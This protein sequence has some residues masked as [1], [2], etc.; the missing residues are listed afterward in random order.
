MATIAQRIKHLMPCSDALIWLG[1]RTNPQKAWD[2]CTMPYWMTWL[3][4]YDTRRGTAL[5]A[6][7]R[8]TERIICHLIE[9]E[10]A[11]ELE[12]ADY[13]RT[14]FPH[15]PTSVITQPRHQESTM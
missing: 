14:R 3:L 10:N 7:I 9:I 15:P 6:K 5:Y 12:A 2:E 8:T 1:K 11:S 13:V 4:R